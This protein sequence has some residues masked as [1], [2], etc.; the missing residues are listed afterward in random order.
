MSQ[1]AKSTTWSR[2]RGPLNPPKNTQ[3]VFEPWLVIRL[4]QLDA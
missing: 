2:T 1:I 4:A 3:T